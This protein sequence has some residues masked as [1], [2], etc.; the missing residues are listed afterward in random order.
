[1]GYNQPNSWSPFLPARRKTRRKPAVAEPHSMTGIGRARVEAKR[2]QTGLPS[3]LTPRTRLMSR[4]QGTSDLTR[5]PGSRPPPP[6]H[7]GHRQEADDL[8]PLVTA[9]GQNGGTVN[10]GG[11]RKELADEPVRHSRV[12]LEAVDPIYQSGAEA[13]RYRHAKLRAERQAE[14]RVPVLR[15]GRAGEPV[16]DYAPNQVDV[17]RAMSGA[18]G[19]IAVTPEQL[20]NQRDLE[21]QGGRVRREADV[22]LAEQDMVRGKSAYQAALNRA[23]PTQ[24]TPRSGEQPSGTVSPQARQGMETSMGQAGQP[25][26][27]MA[28]A[29]GMDPRGSRVTNLQT[30]EQALLAARQTYEAAKAA[31]APAME[32]RLVDTD[33]ARGLRPIQPYG[34]PPVGGVTGAATRLQEQQR[35]EALGLLAR[36][37]AGADPLAPQALGSAIAAH[38]DAGAAMLGKGGSYEQST[39]YETPEGK[40]VLSKLPG[41]GDVVTPRSDIDDLL[42]RQQLEFSRRTMDTTATEEEGD[43]AVANLIGSLA[44]QSAL[45]SVE[46]VRRQI[47]A[48]PP[49]VARYTASQIAMSEHPSLTDQ[50]RQTVKDAA[51]TAGNNVGPTGPS[52]STSSTVGEGTTQTT[53]GS[54]S[55]PTADSITQAITPAIKSIGSSLQRGFNDSDVTQSILNEPTLD[56]WL[57]TT[58]TEAK[59]ANESYDEI[60]R[61]IGNG[62]Y[63]AAYTEMNN[64]IMYLYMDSPEAQ[65]RLKWAEPDDL[66]QIFRDAEK[67]ARKIAGDVNVQIKERINEIY[68]SLGSRSI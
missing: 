66:S 45:A 16:R 46:I 9:L 25:M 23:M 3:G 31:E 57:N 10:I 47:A 65:N 29:T 30:A 41:R 26:S 8:T 44:G 28:T 20:E 35:L 15:G 33:I 60:E 13:N 59:S 62:V 18:T 42:K 54:S 19:P 38:Q 37:P 7:Y 4:R 24:Q 49:K 55:L 2:G 67:I 43:K 39:F 5:L 6:Q 64:R 32:Q 52:A 68:T 48:M 1:M 14:G 58:I 11:L 56:T 50:I 61:T 27:Q 22:T 34:Q 40:A 51:M 21:S 17:R 12:Q 63:N 53:A 36:Q